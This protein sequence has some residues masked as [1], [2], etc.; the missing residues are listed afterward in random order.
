MQPSDH[1]QRQSALDTRRSFVVQAPAGSGKT[2]LLIRRYLCL[3]AQVNKPE[4]ILAITFTIK[5]ADEMR[6]RIVQALRSSSDAE[7]QDENE[8]A[9]WQLARAAMQQDER[10]QWQVLQRTSRLRIQTIDAFCSALVAQMPWSA[11]L[12][13][14][15]E[16]TDNAS[17]LYRQAAMTTLDELENRNTHWPDVIARVLVHLDGDM[18]ALASGLVAMLPQREQWLRFAGSTEQE[19]MSREM[20]QQFWREV[21]DKELQV[22][23]RMIPTNLYEDIAACAS[24]AASNLI[25]AGEESSVN[26]CAGMT[27]IPEA[28]SSQ[29]PQWRGIAELLLLK[30]KKSFRKT[31][32]KRAGFPPGKNGIAAEMK[33]RMLDLLEL[34]SETPQVERALAR[35]RDLPDPSISDE[36]WELM[37]AMCQILRLSAGKL[38]LVF[39]DSGRID[40]TELTHSAGLALGDAGEPTDLALAMDYRIQHLL[41]D[42][43]QDTSYTQQQIVDRLTAGWQGGDGRTLFLVGDP[44]QSIYRFREAEVGLFVNAMRYG[45]GSLNLKTVALHANFRSQAQIVNWVNR[46]FERIFPTQMNAAEGKVSFL[47]SDPFRL[48]DEK[49]AVQLHALV[50]DRENSAEATRI[51]EIVQQSMAQN[52]EGK[53][54][55]LVRSRTHLKR[56]IP[57]LRAAKIPFAGLEIEELKHRMVVQ[58]LLSLTRALLHPADRV[59]WLAIL[60]A[61]WCG[62]T[63]GDL[64]RLCGERRDTPIWGQLCNDHVIAQLTDDG[65]HRAK[66]LREVIQ[67]AFAHRQRRSLRRYVESVWLALGGPACIEQ[68]DIENA[69]VFFDTLENHDTGADI[70]DFEQL[71]RSVARLWA[72]SDSQTQT[73]QIM[74]VHKA[75][76][77][78]FDTVILPGLGRRPGNGNRRSSRMLEWLEVNPGQEEGTLLACKAAKSAKPGEQDPMHTYISDVKLAR[79]NHEQLR[80]LYVA[81]TRAKNR[82]HLIGN[83]NS[84]DK[85]EL[86]DPVKGSALSRLW[87]AIGDEFR[88]SSQSN[89]GKSVP[90]KP[91]PEITLQRLP[92]SW[93]LPVLPEDLKNVAMSLEIKD[94]KPP[95]EFDWAGHLARIVGT[96]VHTLFNEIHTTG[97]DQNLITRSGTLLR[98]VG[99]N[100]EEMDWVLQRVNQAMDNARTDERAQWIFDHRHNEKRSEWAL[101]GVIEG[102]VVKVVIDRSFVDDD[103]TRWIVDFKTSTHEGG[104]VERFLNEEVKRYK[105][106]LQQYGQL[107]SALQS[108]P[109]K[110]GLYFPLLKAWREVP[111]DTDTTINTTA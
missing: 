35:V 20:M 36:Q 53:I 14:S 104:G 7:P 1:A 22:I 87:P 86:S 108:Q 19:A 79:D 24:Y 82:L 84:K 33:Q 109:V 59:A 18:A 57:G 29:L 52:P 61:P 96:V 23:Q 102:R 5:A 105:D 25:S 42:E 34:L 80:L 100:E 58:D 83:L 32:D 71:Y 85:G 67:Q 2:G 110:L 47:E 45:V 94:E 63:L 48:G 98:E 78:E 106:Q 62:L 69:A 90:E 39:Q 31:V 81:C 111:F 101:S 50:D 92:L 97:F 16:L 12:G 9:L 91:V 43:Y 93:Q 40:F 46:V 95:I 37:Q 11:R 72:L 17:E 21:V 13:A 89:L 70:V 49:N 74:T 6:E 68:T 28:D 73:V 107:V 65:Q 27:H 51:V 77:L 99:F 38:K 88:Q 4:E 44:M 103:G 55:I 66:R 41:V 10:M 15:P 75:K 76:G 56:I 8:K 60:R 64:T 30:D 54:A 26:G 3:L